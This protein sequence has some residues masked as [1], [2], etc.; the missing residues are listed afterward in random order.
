MQ[1]PV[2]GPGLPVDNL[3]A[4]HDFYVLLVACCVCS[5]CQLRQVGCVAQELPRGKRRTTANSCDNHCRFARIDIGEPRHDGIVRI[6]TCGHLGGM[7]NYP[8]GL[9]DG[10]TI[11]DTHLPHLN[12]G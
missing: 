1:P 11:H 10:N 5:A 6:R 9:C 2:L 4:E 8:A 7:F 3:S 12:I